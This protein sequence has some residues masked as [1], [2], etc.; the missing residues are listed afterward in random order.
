MAASEIDLEQTREKHL[1]NLK[2]IEK[3]KKPRVVFTYVEAGKGHITATQNVYDEFCKKYGDRAEVI[4]SRFFTETKND[5]LEKTEKLFSRT[6]KDQNR[7]NIYSILCKIGNVLAGDTFAL[8]V[9][10]KLTLSGRKTNPHAVKHIEELDADLI[11]SAHWAI[12]FYANQIKGP[13]PYVVTFCPDVYSN[14]AFNVDCNNFVI[15]TKE[16]YDQLQHFRMYAGG[17]VQHIPYPLRQM[18]EEYRSLEKKL[19]CRQNLGIPKNE[20]VAVLCDGGYGMAKLE[21]TVNHLLKSKEKMTII[22]LC[23]TNHTLYERL[24][25]RQ[26]KVPEH[27]RLIPVDFTDKMLDY[28]ACGDIFVGKGGANAITEPASIGVPIII[29]KCIT[30]IERGTKRYFVRHVKGAMYIPS[31]RAAAKKIRKIIKNPSIL[32]KYKENLSAYNQR[33]YDPEAFADLLWKRVCEMQESD[34]E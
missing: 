17:N 20:F 32:D 13:R 26:D 33:V 7:S 34:G 28:L 3:G 1:K 4:Q 10:L 30:Y 25:K 22:A 24:C 8:Y 5:D 16:G 18:T 29:T 9:L 19:E 27:I 6:V 14:G 21:K 23:G 31:S 11:Y 2:K 15:S 12:P